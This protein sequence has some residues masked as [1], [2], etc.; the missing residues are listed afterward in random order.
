MRCFK[1]VA[2]Q[3]TVFAFQLCE[4]PIAF[5]CR[6]QLALLLLLLFFAFVQVARPIQDCYFLKLHF[7]RYSFPFLLYFIDQ[8]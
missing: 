5:E 3:H 7:P 8:L 1:R 4:F 6:L 2:L